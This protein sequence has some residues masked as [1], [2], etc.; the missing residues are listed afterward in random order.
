MSHKLRRAG[1]KAH[2]SAVLDPFALYGS[3]WVHSVHFTVSD[4]P[5]IQTGSVRS[6]HIEQSIQ[7]ILGARRSPRHRCIPSINE[8]L[9]LGISKLERK[10]VDH[11][12]GK[13][14]PKGHDGDQ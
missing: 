9:S 2:A 3:Q 5:E 10:E 12:G 11:K 1:I 4:A 13:N 8:I 7:R 14:P 6:I